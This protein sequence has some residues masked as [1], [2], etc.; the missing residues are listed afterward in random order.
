MCLLKNH[1]SY[2]QKKENYI[3]L[4]HNPYKMFKEK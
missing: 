4:T 2:S 3:Y 1:K